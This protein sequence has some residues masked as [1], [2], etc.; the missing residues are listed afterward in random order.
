[1]VAIRCCAADTVGRIGT[2]ESESARAS[3]RRRDID[4]LRIMKWALGLGRRPAGGTRRQE[5]I[6]I[7]LAHCERVATIVVSGTSSRA[8]GVDIAGRVDVARHVGVHVD[9]SNALRMLI[10][11]RFRSDIPD[12]RRDVAKY[13]AAEEH[14]RRAHSAIPRRHDE[15][16]R[17]SPHLDES[18]HDL[19]LDVGLVA[20]RD[21]HRLSDVDSPPCHSGFSTIS[22][23]VPSRAARTI[24]ASLPMTATT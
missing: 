11:D 24:D 13:R 21:Y 17:L 23:A 19:W 16:T 9:V 15:L 5:I 12:E 20:E 6:A 2:A 3:A 10:H 8:E 14:R 7:F 1:M 4:H 22:A 18:P